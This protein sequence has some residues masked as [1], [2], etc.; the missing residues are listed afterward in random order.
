MSNEIG[1]DKLIKQYDQDNMVI[2]RIITESNFYSGDHL[3][4]IADNDF[5]NRV[6]K[7]GSKSVWSKKVKNRYH[8]KGIKTKLSDYR[9]LYY[10]P[11]FFTRGQI[12]LRILESIEISTK[13]GVVY[14]MPKRSA[15]SLNTGNILVFGN[16]FFERFKERSGL[17][18]NN[19]AEA[20]DFF[21]FYMSRSIV[22]ESDS[23][24]GPEY[25]YEA[26]KFD[27]KYGLCLSS[28]FRR[29]ET[30]I[31][32]VKTFVNKDMLFSDQE[33][34]LSNL[35]ETTEYFNNLLEVF[36]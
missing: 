21:M 15:F 22:S 17:Y 32:F 13:S 1:V 31:Y 27:N 25:G 30:K 26:C 8:D 33:I 16:H 23:I 2:D 10:V 4:N 5:I 34:D 7:D 24:G 28:I 29:G 14:S 12:T 6:E 18:F 11:T 35:S 36:L 3:R 19:T 9:T 20:R